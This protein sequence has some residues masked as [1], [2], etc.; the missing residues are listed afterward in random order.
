MTWKYNQREAVFDCLRVAA[1][2]MVILIHVLAAWTKTQ[3]A[4]QTWWFYTLV[5]GIT[6]WAVPIFFMTSGKFLLSRGKL[7]PFRVLYIRYALRTFVMWTVWTILYRFS[8]IGFENWV[9]AGWNLRDFIGVAITQ[10]PYHLWFLQTLTWIYLL[11]PL[12]WCVAKA[13]NGK[14]LG[15][16]C[17]LFFLCTI[18]WHTLEL[19]MPVQKK[20]MTGIG[21]FIKPVLQYAGYFLL[22]GYLDQ[23]DVSRIK[24]RWLFAAFW[25]VVLAG[26]WIQAEYG[27]G[28]ADVRMLFEQNMTIPTYLKAV[29][30]FVM[31]KVLSVRQPD[32]VKA[33]VSAVAKVSP[34]ML[35]VY[36]SHVYVIDHLGPWF[37]WNMERMSPFLSIPLFTV[38]TFAICLA[39]AA[40]AKKIPLLRKCR[41]LY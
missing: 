22:G 9:R 33:C 14:Y 18:C 19:C 27:E 4:D 28:S 34:H 6:R 40:I 30:V 36:L 20:W 11:L 21:G 39:A 32:G 23:K 41:W 10:Q 29:L 13:E 8:M 38:V 12:L 24:V 31:C 37:G 26:V 1:S 16:A 7:P 5:D 25:A 15:W 35:F 17:A 3:Q 2:F